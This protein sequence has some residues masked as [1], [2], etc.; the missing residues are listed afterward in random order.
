MREIG[1]GVIAYLLGIGTAVLFMTS[2]SASWSLWSAAPPLAMRG[3]VEEHH[4]S[5][6]PQPGPSISPADSKPLAVNIVDDADSCV[7]CCVPVRSENNEQC[8]MACVYDA[9]EEKWRY[10]RPG[11]VGKE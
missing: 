6:V 5:Y 9:G 7:R 2:D 1:T 11:D 8:L 4:R 3:T 10:L